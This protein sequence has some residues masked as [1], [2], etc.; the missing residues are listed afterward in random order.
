MEQQFQLKHYGKLSIFEQNQM[1]A[2]ERSWFIKRLE[3]EFKDKQEKEQQ[4]Q[5]SARTPSRPSI[6]RR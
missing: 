5:R 2:E 3:K 6:P 4:Q 1:T